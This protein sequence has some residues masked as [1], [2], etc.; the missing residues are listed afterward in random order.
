[1]KRNVA[2]LVYEDVEVLDFAGPFEVFSV[3]SQLNEHRFFN[4]ELVAANRSPVRAINGMMVLPNQTFET[5][6]APDILVIPGGNGSRAA[7]K[8]SVLLEWTQRSIAGAEIV[9]SIC[10]GA[11]ILAVLGHLA[12]RA[13]TTH[14]QVFDHVKE[15]EP[16]VR[17]DAGKRFV[18]AGKFVTTGGISAGI[19]GSF[20]VVSRLLGEGI[21]DQCARYM[22]YRRLPED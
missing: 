19:D 3:T 4:V 17:L 9:L 13:A 5:S 1:M 15:L 16:L 20:H 6:A 8:D 10:S 11:R 21:A 2:I 22:E 7:M 18:D 12:G 14:H